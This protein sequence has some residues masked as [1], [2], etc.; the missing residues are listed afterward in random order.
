MQNLENVLAFCVVVWA[1]VSLLKHFAPDYYTK[2][3]NQ[4]DQDIHKRLKEAETKI[5]EITKKD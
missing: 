3:T 4:W 5:E 2:T 1:C